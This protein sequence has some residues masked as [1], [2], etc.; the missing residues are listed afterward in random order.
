MVNIS[1][2]KLSRQTPSSQ[3]WCNRAKRPRGDAAANVSSWHLADESGRD[4]IPASRSW[5]T[6]RITLSVKGRIM[7]R[8]E[9]G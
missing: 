1:L 5:I 7:R 9:A 3:V 2:T 4:F 8:R 6:L